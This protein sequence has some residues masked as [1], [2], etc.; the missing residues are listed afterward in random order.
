[1]P[2]AQGEEFHQLAREVLVRMLL[3][4]LGLVEPEQHGG[5]A[6]DVHQQIEPGPGRVPSEH[7]ILPPHQEGV[8][9]LDEA[10]GEVPV[11][12]QRHFLLQRA[13]GGGHALQPP[14][15]EFDEPPPLFSLLL[16][17]QGAAFLLGSLACLLQAFDAGWIRLGPV[18]TAGL[19]GNSLVIQE[20]RHGAVVSQRGQA[21]DLLG[22][23]AESRPVQQMRGMRGIPPIRWQDV[24]HL[25]PTDGIGGARVSPDCRGRKRSICIES[26]SG[27][28]KAL[29]KSNV[30]LNTMTK[31]GFTTRLAPWSRRQFLTR[32]IAAA[33]VALFT[34]R[35][36]AEAAGP[37]RASDL[38][39]LGRTGLRVSRLALGTGYNGYARSSAQTRLGEGAC[40]DLLRHGYDAGVRFLDMA[41]L[42]GSHDYVKRSLA[43]RDR[44]QFCLLSKIW[45]RE[46]EWNQPSGGALREVDR[47]RKELNTDVLDV[48]LIHCTTDSKWPDKFE[49]VRDELSELKQK[50]V[51]RAV[52]TSCHDFGALKVAAEHPWVDVI[53]ARINHMGGRKYS[54]DGSAEEVAA[55]LKQARARGKAVVGMKI[56]GAGKL[57]EPD[58]K[59]ASL[60][61]V[62]ENNL[63]DAVT[64]GMVSTGEVDDTIRRMDRVL[65]K[66]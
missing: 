12:E 55:V 5:I 33:G 21:L 35:I 45:T 1:M 14:T 49:R 20:L 11:P 48:C 19:V 42:Y 8:P 36:V 43:G 38:V 30:L 29:A 28:L 3:P 47:F 59:D 46:E 2:F 31:R 27:V 57:V 32:S 58:Q 24:Q 26:V 62:F 39:P 41:D 7:I 15:L 10:G 16:A 63:V 52:G 40:V 17:K 25:A 18:G 61:F 13:L 44:D 56:F 54:M 66:V 50:Q 22:G 53:F 23:T 65:G 37:R 34:P 64:I 60:K 4:A 6:G 9:H 51:V